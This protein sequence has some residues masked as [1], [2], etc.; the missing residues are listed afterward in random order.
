M[1]FKD[2]LATLGH[3]TL[4]HQNVTAYQLPMNPKR[5][6]EGLVDC[7]AITIPNKLKMR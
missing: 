5:S 3:T 2:I 1:V 4:V 7:W 6:Q